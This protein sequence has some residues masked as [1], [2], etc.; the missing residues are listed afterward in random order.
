[1]SSEQLA[2]SGE[3]QQKQQVTCGI[4]CVYLVSFWLPGPALLLLL[5]LFINTKPGC[6]QGKSAKKGSP[7]T[8]RRVKAKDGKSAKEEL[9]PGQ[10]EA[11][12]RAAF[13][14]HSGRHSSPLPLSLSGNFFFLLPL[15]ERQ[16]STRYQEGAADLRASFCASFSSGCVER[17]C[18]Y[19]TC[20]R[21]CE[22][23]CVCVLSQ[24]LSTP[25]HY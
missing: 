5:C 7:G 13:R 25:L 21:V 24:R 17:L 8:A 15:R 11:R 22:Y 12:Q 19:D 1:M 23:M 9:S 10:K 14:A 20:V 6:A 16:K 2:A 3:K 4:K 18:Q